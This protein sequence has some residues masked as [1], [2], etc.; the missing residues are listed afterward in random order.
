MISIEEIIALQR[1][2]LFAQQESGKKADK[3]PIGGRGHSFKVINKGKEKEKG[4]T[5]K[6]P[7]P[8]QN[9]QRLQMTLPS[10]RRMEKGK[11]GS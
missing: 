9:K 7:A 3:G 2:E 10:L 1:C 11:W 4:I 5:I 8:S 6:E